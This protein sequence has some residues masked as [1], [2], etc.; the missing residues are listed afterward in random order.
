M[1]AVVNHLHFKEP[2][3]PA[4]FGRAADELAEPMRAI[5]GF[6]G[7]DVVLVDDT[8]A[9]LII[10]GASAEVCDEMAT[11]VGS[12]WMGANVVPLLAGPPERSVGAV[13]AQV[14]PTA[15]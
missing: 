14:T 7:L 3:D 1:H 12:P 4:L 2:I 9:I 6:G 8:H 13:V 10:R 5:A 11:K 15:R